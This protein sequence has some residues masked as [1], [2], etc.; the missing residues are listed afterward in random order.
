MPGSIQSSVLG[1]WNALRYPLNTPGHRRP[2]RTRKH[3][4]RRRK[5]RAGGGFGRQEVV[6]LATAAR[7]TADRGG[8]VLGQTA[9]LES[10]ERVVVQTPDPG[11]TPEAEDQRRNRMG[12]AADGWRRGCSKI[13]V[14]SGSLIKRMLLVLGYGLGAE[15]NVVSTGLLAK[16]ALASP[17]QDPRYEDAAITR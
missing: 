4:A 3:N 12:H 11:D 2:A 7:A 8:D 5:S 17:T 14:G 13:T 9:G 1:L 10:L 16:H 15:P 6:E